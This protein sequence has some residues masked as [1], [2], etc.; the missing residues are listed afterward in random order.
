MAKTHVSDCS[1]AALSCVWV[2]IDPNARKLWRSPALSCVLVV[3]GVAFVRFG[4]SGRRC[5]AF[6][7][8]PGG[9]APVAQPHTPSRRPPASGLRE[10]F[11]SSFQP[12]PKSRVGTSEHFRAPGGLAETPRRRPC[13]PRCR[14]S[15]PMTD[16]AARMAASSTLRA[17]EA[18][19]G[20]TE[21]SSSRRGRPQARAAARWPPTARGHRPCC[22]RHSRRCGTPRWPLP[23]ER[24]CGSRRRPAGRD[25]ST[26]PGR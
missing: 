4:R 1:S 3:A 7:S 12:S 23:S 6:G 26:P 17:G 2:E 8:R 13:A 9:P 16:E 10:T 19:T 14:Q 21:I 25:R 20:P 24:R 11:W 5:R 18:P 15:S 22:A